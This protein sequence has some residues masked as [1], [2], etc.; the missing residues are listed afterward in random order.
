M[1]NS[2]KENQKMVTYSNPVGGM[3][4]IG[5]PFVLKKENSY[6]MYATSEPNF[7]F[8]VWKS[9]NLVNW[10]EK[11]LAYVHHEQP[12]KWATGDFWAPEVIHRNNR[13]Y[14]TYSARNKDGHLQISVAASSDPLGPFTDISTEIIKQE[15]SYI[16]GHIFIGDDGTPYL[17]YV[18]DCSENKINGNHVSQILVQEMNKEITD[19]LGEP[20]LLLEPDQPWEG[21]EGDYQWNE[22]P[23]VMKDGQ[24]Y[25]LMY[26]ANCFASSDYS[27]GYA[28]S[29]QPLGPFKKATENPILAKNLSINI[30]GP[31]HN[32]VTIGPDDK[33][34]YIVY[35]THTNPDAPSGNRQMNIDRLYFEEGKLIVDGPIVN[36]QTIKIK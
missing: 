35:H 10:E 3:N 19:V 2:H 18:K 27:V 6:Y 9:D 26:S 8:K 16:D 32:S 14:M 33:T 20:R 29:D 34:L 22:G 36:E 4:K 31:G 17:Y 12:N 30:S 21:I 23:F 28:T 15:G 11:G 13:Y 24:T 5:D 25:Y 7:G 1:V